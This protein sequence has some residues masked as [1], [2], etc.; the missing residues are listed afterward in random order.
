MQSQGSS[1]PWRKDIILWPSQLPG[2]QSWRRHDR[3]QGRFHRDDPDDLEVVFRNRAGGRD[4]RMWVGVIAYQAG[5][6]EYLGILLNSPVL[7]GTIRQ[8]DNVAFTFPEAAPYPLAVAMDGDYRRAGLPP[9]APPAF[10]DAMADGLNQ[11]RQGAFG[12]NQAGIAAAVESFVR[13][14]G[15]MT[16]ETDEASRFARHFFLARCYAEQ[17]H[18]LEAIREFQRA[19]TYRPD[20]EDAQMGLLA[21]YSV[22]AHRGPDKLP[23]GNPEYWAQQFETQVSVVKRRFSPEADGNRIIDELFSG[24]VPEE[25]R[26]SLR[27]EQRDALHRI[28]PGSFRWKTK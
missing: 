6:P 10:R 2:D 17:Y 14:E 5:P 13:A 22:L 20:D 15:V 3:L 26:R 4:E 16:N 1:A 11:Y 7:I 18:T 12:H 19:V 21:E 23:I 9:M 28:G 8:G 24:E 27:K 25:E